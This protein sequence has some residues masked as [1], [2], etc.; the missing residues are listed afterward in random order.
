MCEIK[1]E[2]ISHIFFSKLPHSLIHLAFYYA[3]NRLGLPVVYT[4]NPHFGGDYVYPVLQNESNLFQKPT[5][6]DEN[7]YKFFCDSMF[8]RNL[9][10]NLE[11]PRYMTADL[12]YMPSVPESHTPFFR[13]QIAYK[14]FKLTKARLLGDYTGR[15]FELLQAAFSVIKRLYIYNNYVTS[16][17][18]NYQE[19]YILILLQYHP[20]QTTSPSA[21]DTPFEEERISLLADKYPNFKIF[22]REHPSN[23]KTQS[24]SFFQYRN[25]RAVKKMLRA[26]N[27]YYLW[28][29]DRLSYKE[30]IENAF[31]TMSTNS[32]VAIESILLRTPTVHFSNSF[33]SGFPGVLIA[34]NVDS[35]TL[36]LIDKLQDQLDKLTD[37]ELV[38]RSYQTYS[39]HDLTQGFING[40]HELRY[41]GEQYITGASNIIFSSLM[42]LAEK[43]P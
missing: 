17:E 33:A 18:L 27:V 20:E 15:F 41:S 7:F 9:N 6:H 38:E 8:A 3:S 39:K 4:E 26:K 12:S 21:L 34:K 1:K 25:L 37:G 16:S 43:T 24:G 19:R 32:T 40:Y 36:P 11:P 31:F 42:K 10:K 30:L 28:P 14:I 5:K 2:N 35:I 22:V 13:S 29:S 23:L